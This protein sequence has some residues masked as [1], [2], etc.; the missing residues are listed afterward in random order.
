MIGIAVLGAGHWG[1]NLIRHFDNRHTS[2]VRWVVDRDP[3]RLEQVRRRFPDATLGTDADA[4]I[5]DPAVDA[6]VIATPTSTHHALAS[7][8]LRRGK[9]VLVEKPLTADVG[10]G[11]ELQRLA[12]ETGL[13]LMVGH[14][15]LYNAAV[16]WVK[17]YLESGDLGR[18][19][20]IS[21]V[22]TNLGPIR[23]DV[24]AGW[25]LAAHDVSIFNYWLDAE[26]DHVSAVGGAWINEGIADA[27]FATLEYPGGVLANLHV[28]WLNPR[29]ARDITVAGQDR[30]L[31]LDDLSLTEPVRIYDKT[32]TD[33]RVRPGFIDSFASF[34]ASVRDGDITIPKISLGEPLQAECEQFVESV[35]SG[36]PPHTGA[37]EGL[38]VVRTLE[39]IDRSIAAGGARQSV[40]PAGVQA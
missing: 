34:R 6:V 27:V 23:M 5:G 30:M 21:A 37:R 32:V 12:E 4:A 17:R 15:F 2:E 20:Y 35:R 26:P 16:Q 39:A 3:E 22:R 13:V 10:E 29:K 28:S 11:E 33:E 7:M 31:T 8:A 40:A 14:V 19:Y 36:D 1:P 18:V 9:H 38:R 24:N 25:D